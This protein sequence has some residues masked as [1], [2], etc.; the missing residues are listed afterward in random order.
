MKK[1]FSIISLGCPRNLVDSEH[2][3]SEFIDN[4]YVFKEDVIG[5]DTVI[6]NTCAFIEDA[7]KES[8]DT[9]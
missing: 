4:G 9:I 6:I 5:S 8:I 3:M 7:K 1:T 2:I